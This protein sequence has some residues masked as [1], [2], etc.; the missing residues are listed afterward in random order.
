MTLHH[1]ESLQEALDLLSER[2]PRV[3]AGGTDVYPALR[4]APP[5][6]E[7]MDITR[8]A[9]LRGITAHSGGWR[10]GG[11]TPWRDIYKADLPPLFDGLVAAAREVGSVQ[12]QATG[13]IAGNI[14]NAS[15]AADGVPA[16]LAMGAEVELSNALGQRRMCLADFIQGPRKTALQRDE[17]LTA[18][19]IPA[20]MGRGAFV[21]LGARRYLVISIAMVGVVVEMTGDRID[22]AAVAV[23]ACS[24]VACRLADLEAAL[25]GAR[26][27]DV[28]AIVEAA[29]MPQ[30]TP[31]SDVRARAEY[32]TDAVRP[33]VTRAILAA[34]EPADVA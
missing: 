18:I 13:T 21:K 32:R 3:L 22:H 29:A 6:A 31:I 24:P 25:T 34:M 9:G 1:P 4:D 16:L 30:I 2:A 14:C 7:M 19:H 15:P 17:L 12:I 11:A 27:A 20:G 5:P 26:G 10:I 8:V 23:G 33:L 28:A